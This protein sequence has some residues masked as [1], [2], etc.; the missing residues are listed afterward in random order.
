MSACA[1][2][3]GDL[4]S[5]GGGGF[6][7]WLCRGSPVHSKTPSFSHFYVALLAA[8]LTDGDAPQHVLHAPRTPVHAH[9]HHSP[10]PTTAVL[11][12]SNKGQ[13]VLF[14]SSALEFKGGPGKCSLLQVGKSRA[15][16]I[17]PPST[18]QPPATRIPPQPQVKSNPTPAPTPESHPKPTQ[19]KPNHKKAQYPPLPC[20]H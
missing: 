5:G 2:A 17:P 10:P 16:A 15:R 11:L 14:P 12:R 9:H 1:S 3:N 7:P 8:H 19:T 4:S 13:R 18:H 6:P 20:P